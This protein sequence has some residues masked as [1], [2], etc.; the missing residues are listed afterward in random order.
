[1]KKIALF[2]ACAVACS[3]AAERYK[4]RMFDVEVKKQSGA[5]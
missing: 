1:M 4:D 5:R 2:L 3:S